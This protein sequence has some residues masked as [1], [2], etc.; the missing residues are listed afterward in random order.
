ML[1][2]PASGKT[3]FL[4]ALTIAL[5]RRGNEWKVVGTDDASTDILIRL[6]AALGDG[7]FPR[8]THGI[9]RFHWMLVGRVMGGT[10]RRRSDPKRH[11]EIV[12]IGLDVADAQGEI[13]ADRRRHAFREDL[14]ND[15][16][17]S[18]GIILF[19]DPTNE[20][21]RGDAFDHT[22]G[23]VAQ[24]AQ[25]MAA[26]PG[27]DVLPHYVAV[28]ISKFDDAR[29]YA[30]AEELNLVSSDPNDPYGF[31]RVHD[32]DARDFFGHLCRLSRSG[33]ADMV[34][35]TLEQQ[36]RPDRIKYFV[37]SAIG[38]YLDPFVGVYDPGDHQNRWLDQHGQRRVRIRGP[39]HPI[40]VVEP[41]VWL[42]R[43]LTENPTE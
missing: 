26:A 11:E 3:T 24:L 20:S 29:V 14:I 36:F 38:F 31:P 40:N 21:A 34:Q 37:S 16:V 41:L 28:C 27:S 15:V 23:V 1:G 32:D 10:R 9:D 5:A 42:A 8:A 2:A 39:I 19:F 43:Q 30:T 12:R 6:T 22:F 13:L 33:T 35:S 7:T 18:R 17:R 4:A 25:E